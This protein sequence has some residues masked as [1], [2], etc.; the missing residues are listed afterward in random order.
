MIENVNYLLNY[1]DCKKLNICVFAICIGRI[2]ANDN[3]NELN[4]LV[5]KYNAELIAQR[6][7][8]NKLGLFKRKEKQ[9]LQERIRQTQCNIT[10]TQDKIAEVEGKIKPLEQEVAN[11]EKAIAKN[12]LKA[13]EIEDS[14]MSTEE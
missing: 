3:Y 1:L 14:L 12:A 2:K 5:S 6:A 8:L 10:S 4:S 7:E 11:V 9:E 13:K